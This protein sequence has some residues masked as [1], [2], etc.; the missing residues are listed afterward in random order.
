MFTND[1]RQAFRLML[2]EPGFTLAAVL[3]L[4]L[5]VG[6]NVA[7]FALVETVLLRPLPYTAGDQ[8]AVI[9]HRDQRTGITKD[10]IAIGDYIDLAHRQTA[11]DGFASYDTFQSTVSGLGEPFRAHGL[12]GSP[13]LLDTLGVHPALGRA[14]QSAD[15]RK[16]AAHVIL[17]TDEMWRDHLGSDPSILGR[18]IKIGD[19][20]HQVIGVL[21]PG[22]AFPPDSRV[23]IVFPALLPA[24]APA[25]RKS[26]WTFAIARLKSGMTLQQSAAH[27]G[28]VS[29]QLEQEFPTSNRGSEYYPVP[30]REA[31]VGNTG[32]ALVLML[33]AATLVLLIASANVANLLMARSLARRREM[34]VRMALGAGYA[35][36]MAQLLTESVALAAVAGSTGILIGLWMTK[37]I[38]AMIPKSLSVPGL[39]TIHMNLNVLAFALALTV[40][41]AIVCGLTSAFTVRTGGSSGSLVSPTRVTAGA[42]TRRSAA[43][44]VVTEVALAIVLLIGAGLILRTLTRLISVDPGFQA[45]HVLSMTVQFPADR[46]R[47]VGARRA[48]YQRGFA[49]LKNMPE[50]RAAGVAAVTPLTGNNWTVGFQRADQ[51]VAAGE[52]PPE[53]GWQVASGGYFQALQIPLR[54]GR[55]FDDRDITGRLVV[56]ISEAIER[57]FF[58]NESAVGREVLIGERRAE[59]VG[60]V[61]NI[62]RADIRE[63][64]RADMYFSFEN[65]P[66]NQ[67]T[68]FVQTSGEPTAATSA[69]QSA[70]KAIEPGMVILQT[71][72]MRD[73]VADGFRMTKLVLW[74]LGVF[75]ATAL[76]LAAVGI[77][78]V[79][80]YMVR[81]RMREIGTRIAL[82]ASRAD[83]LWL[84]MKRGA[85][86]A[87][88]GCGIGAGIALV[89]T[90]WLSSMLYGVSASDPMTLIL[91]T[92]VLTVTVLAACCLP[93]RRAAAIDP[94]KI[95]AES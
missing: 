58:P 4:A 94:A 60:V 65:E 54:S 1:I 47:D 81:Q 88:L 67:I 28:L 37:A 36:L 62:R 2:R 10:F 75:A 33:A 13:E 92:I 80:A 14:F 64:P 86:I 30:L 32:S 73:I 59:I 8:L 16:G 70:L 87:G 72:S 85:V 7:V 18:G 45:D 79:M 29:R 61:G 24:A 89:V 74:L 34:A 53:V 48:L 46:Y 6:V 12:A 55:L 23:D 93:A 51:P 82:G 57:R 38:V 95:L 71:R 20:E 17:I 68:F 31:L 56:I 35:R 69:V 91:A 78:G 39:S 27:L 49:A 83:I 76:A 22:F 11:F 42:Q 63:Q 50:I 26:G 52:R 41:T 90:R 3:T 43:A 15:S 9:R 44:L 21:P 66:G 84:V 40:G 19:A 25:E 77:Y 5:G